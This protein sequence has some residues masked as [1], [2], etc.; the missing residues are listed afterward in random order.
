MQFQLWRIGIIHICVRVGRTRASS[1]SKIPDNDQAA[2]RLST[3]IFICERSFIFCSVL[4]TTFLVFFRDLLLHVIFIFLGFV[5]AVFFA[6]D[7]A[8]F[9]QQLY[10]A[11]T[12]LRRRAR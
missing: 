5:D 7:C 1:K 12:I 8:T 9:K 2:K 6:S 10:C 11:M 3:S 4:L